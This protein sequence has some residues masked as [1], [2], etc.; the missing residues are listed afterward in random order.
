[1]PP[2][3]PK[4]LRNARMRFR[5]LKRATELFTK[6]EDTLKITEPIVSPRTPIMMVK[7]DFHQVLKRNLEL[8]LRRDASESV[9]ADNLRAKLSI[10]ND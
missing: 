9:L 3:Q 1:M 5:I 10:Q 6:A 7:T 4:S 2:Q 8:T